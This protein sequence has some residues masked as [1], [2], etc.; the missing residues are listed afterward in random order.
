MNTVNGKKQI[1]ARLERCQHGCELA[2]PRR[3]HTQNMAQI[4][5]TKW[6]GLDTAFRLSSYPT[7]VKA[8]AL[9]SSGK[10][11]G[12]SAAKHS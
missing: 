3:L 8:V 6:N 11:L 1:D 10:V 4:A 2:H 9:S 12:R 5:V 7:F